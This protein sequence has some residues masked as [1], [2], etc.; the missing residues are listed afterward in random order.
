MDSSD[1]KVWLLGSTRVWIFGFISNSAAASN[2]CTNI[3]YLLSFCT[4]SSFLSLIRVRTL[5]HPLAQKIETIKIL[6]NNWKEYI[7]YIKHEKLMATYTYQ[8]WQNYKCLHTKKNLLQ[9]S[10]VEHKCIYTHISN[11]SKRKKIFKV[12]LESFKTITM[13][14]VGH[15]IHITLNLF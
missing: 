7:E 4:S 6:V 10:W 2:S 8:Y 14:T 3:G 11:K 1:W 15:T 13:K 9:P 5:V 12:A